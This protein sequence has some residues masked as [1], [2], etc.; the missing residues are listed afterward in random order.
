MV[1]VEKS[2]QKD[3]K[4]EAYKDVTTGG[5]DPVE[6]VDQLFT[7]SP[8]LPRGQIHNKM[9]HCNECFSKKKGRK[10]PA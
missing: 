9:S 1:H 8:C 3:Q 10:I 5:R 6:E 4:V 2:A 7:V